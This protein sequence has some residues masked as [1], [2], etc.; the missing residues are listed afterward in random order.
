LR[1]K[2]AALLPV[3]RGA[4]VDVEALELRDLAFE[5][6][7]DAGV[8]AGAVAEDEQAGAVGVTGV[9]QVEG[10]AQVRA[11]ADGVVAVDLGP[12]VVELQNLLALFERAVA[13]LR[14]EVGDAAVLNIVGG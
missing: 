4:A 7:S 9:A 11:E 8:R 6:R 1:V 2:A 3:G 10:V 5:D 13:V 14:A 12:I